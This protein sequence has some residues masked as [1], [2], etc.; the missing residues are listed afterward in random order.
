MNSIVECIYEYSIKKTEKLCVADGCNEFTYKEIWDRTVCCAN[1][2]M[3]QLGIKRN[4]IVLVEC[5]QNATFIVVDMACEL[6]GAVFV[7]FAH[8]ASQE[9]VDML[10]NET[11]AKLVVHETDYKL[12]DIKGKHVS[13]IEDT[14]AN[15]EEYYS[16]WGNLLPQGAELA[17][18]LFT[19]G[20]TGKAKGI[21]ITN[22]ANVAL[23]ENISYG[24]KMLS[25]NVELIPLPLN[26]SH[27]LRC[28][29]A[30]LLMGATIVLIEGVT[31][32]GNLLKLISKYNV[33]SMD[34]SPSAALIIEKLSKGKLVDYQNQFRYIEVGTA[35]L[36]EKERLFLKETFPDTRLYDFYGATESGRTCV[37][38][39]NHENKMPKCIGKCTK[40]ASI[41][42]IDDDGGIIENSSED[43]MGRL[44]F[45]GKMNM[46]GYYKDS[47]LTDEVL[48]DGWVITS[49]LGYVDN[50]GYVYLFGREKDIINYGGI[51]ISPTEVEEAALRT[52]MLT[53]CACV[54]V[55]DQ[56]NGQAP[57]LFVVPKTNVFDDVTF[58]SCLISELDKEKIPK[59]I[60]I[61]D[62]I[63]RSANGKILRRELHN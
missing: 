41:K 37:I 58:R 3:K 18:I 31:R 51:K 39:F 47:K 52:N 32:I 11:G 29:Y 34:I 5:T 44:A 55:D 45:F 6:I 49:D 26:H 1:F 13:D 50:E 9:S 7:P 38:D 30:N 60:E 23:A 43:K 16:D 27:A 22:D 15:F 21:E 14:I 53:E 42:V 63:P 24:V 40:N 61:I 56:I 10:V 4:N 46:R 33:T 8:K 54:A 28:C 35:V 2:L 36:Q 25:D 12:S 19:T 59:I 57:K 62:K 48:L 20:T 17:E